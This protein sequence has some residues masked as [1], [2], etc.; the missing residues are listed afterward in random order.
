MK[1]PGRLTDWERSEVRKA[2]GSDVLSQWVI[3]KHD[4]L[5][6]LVEKDPEALLPPIEDRIL[7]LSD[8]QQRS[9]RAA[10]GGKRFAAA[11]AA[12]TR[13]IELTELAQQRFRR[14]T[15]SP[16]LPGAK[17]ILQRG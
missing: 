11:V 10:W 9:I 7:H 13:A 8:R 6:D 14:R 17:R 4:A 2:V 5:A 16:R 15:T 12:E 1:T 3:D